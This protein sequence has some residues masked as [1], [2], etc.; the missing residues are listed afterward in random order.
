MKKEIFNFDSNDKKT[1]L[2]AV[3][4]IP[5][6]KPKCLLITVHGM[7]EYIE[8]YDEFAS[9]LAKNDIAFYGYDLLGHGDSV[10]SNED[11]G[12]FSEDDGYLI[13]QKDT[14]KLMEIAKSEYNDVPCFIMGHSMGSFIVRFFTS[15]HSN[16]I[17]GSI[18][19]GTGMQPV[20]A[21]K[22]GV[23]A[24]KTIALFKGWHHRSKFI[25]SLVI[26]P[27]NKKWEPS[28]THC[29]WLSKNEDSNQKYHDDPKCGYR[30]T[31]NGFLTLFKTIEKTL[32]KNLVGNIRKDLP[33]LLVSGDEDPVGSCGKEVKAV[34]DMFKELGLN[35]TTMKL[36]EGDRHEILNELDKEQVYQD[37]LEWINGNLQ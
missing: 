34:Y 6:N 5:D 24:C 8:R 11:L 35:N 37:I 9:F 21:V 22:F 17:A 23:L 16:E 28:K 4:Y 30:F 14:Q 27:Y 10:S 13:V 20:A 33:I 12:F 32:D 31:L 25:N 29:E 18:I 1:S 2:K 26:G 3:K 15:M 7:C 36:Y 19:M